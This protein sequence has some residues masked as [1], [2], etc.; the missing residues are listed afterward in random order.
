M[1]RSFAEVEEHLS[2][3]QLLGSL[4]MVISSFPGAAKDIIYEYKIWKK[5]ED[6]EESNVNPFFLVLGD[7]EPDLRLICTMFP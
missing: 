4:F 5:K 3:K 6:F 7:F 2:T 1:F